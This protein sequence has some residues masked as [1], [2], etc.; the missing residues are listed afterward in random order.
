MF[1]TTARVMDKNTAII[2]FSAL[3]K[4]FP[5]IAVLYP[6]GHQPLTQC[7]ELHRVLAAIHSH[8]HGRH[9]DK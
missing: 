2:Y 4:V 3:T 8:D 7:L 9:E 1:V 6:C 5:A